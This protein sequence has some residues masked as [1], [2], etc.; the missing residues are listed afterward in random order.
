[1]SITKVNLLPGDDLSRS[2]WDGL[3]QH[4]NTEWVAR[5]LIQK[6]GLS[7]AQIKNAH[8]QAAQ[9]RYCLDQAFEYYRAAEAVALATKATL[10]YYSALALATAEILYKQTGREQP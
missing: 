6:H 4:R 10:L 3:R 2:A 7:K 8:K 5:K 9:I 1:M